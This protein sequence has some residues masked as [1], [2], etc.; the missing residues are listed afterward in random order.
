[1]KYMLKFQHSAKQVAVILSMCLIYSC[2]PEGS[3]ILGS[4]TDITSQVDNATKNAPFAYDVAL[5]T[6]SYAYPY[7][8]RNKKKERSVW[9]L[10][11]RDIRR[12]A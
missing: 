11:G 6:I 10:G 1:M 7:K 12:K 2:T 5:D 3:G 8:S 9:Y 4:S